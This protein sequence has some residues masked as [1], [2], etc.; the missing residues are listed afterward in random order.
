MGA[1]GASQALRIAERYGIPKEVVEQARETLGDQAQDLA[2]MIERL[3]SA[4]KQARAAQSEADRRTGE[5]RTAEARAKKKLA[6]A[7]EIAGPRTPR[8]TR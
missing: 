3:E 1:P 2:G 5:L 6:E 4:Q 8:R 7:D